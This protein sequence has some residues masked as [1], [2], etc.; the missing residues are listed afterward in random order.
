MSGH[1]PFVLTLSFDT[2]DK[3]AKAVVALS[4]ANASATVVGSGAAVPQA[5]PPPPTAGAAPVPVSAPTAS[6]ATSAPAPAPPAQSPA[7]TAAPSD[8]NALTWDGDVLP[9]YKA[10]LTKHAAAAVQAVNQQFGVQTPLQI[11]ARPHDW[12][13][14]VQALAA[15]G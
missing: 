9:A 1:A 11:K 8:G 12:P 15:L 10:A 5:S 7:P 6:V 2:I 3:L 4:Q 13:G 14:Y